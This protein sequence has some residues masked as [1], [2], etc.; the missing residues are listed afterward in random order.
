MFDEVFAPGGVLETR[1]SGYE[2]RAG[3]RQMA[4]AVKNAIGRRSILLAEAGTGT[5]KTFAYC[6]PAILSGKR[7]VIS[8]ATKN[9][10][11]QIAQ[12]DLPRLCEALSVKARI[13]VLKGR[14][15]YLCLH[16]LRKVG[17]QP[18]VRFRGRNETLAEIMEW[19]A[20]TDT[21]DRAELRTLPDDYLPWREL[22]ARSDICLGPRCSEYEQCFVTRA[23]QAAAAADIVVVNHALF[24]ADLALRQQ[25]NVDSTVLPAYDVVIFDEAH[26]L[27]DA[28]T[29][30]FGVTFSE[31]RV[32]ELQKDVLQ[33]LDDEPIPGAP[34][35]K[36][37]LAELPMAMGALFHALGDTRDS[38]A[39][40][41]TRGPLLQLASEVARAC[42][43]LGDELQEASDH[44]SA[45]RAAWATLSQR[46]KKLSYEVAFVF[47]PEQ[48]EAAPQFARMIE[49]RARSRSIKALPL[50]VGGVLGNTIFDDGSTIILTSATLSVGGDF[51]VLRQRL[52]IQAAEEIVVDSPFDYPHRALVYVPAQFPEPNAPAYNDTLGQR[53]LELCDASKGGAFFL[54]T[55]LAQL[56]RQAQAIGP[57]LRAR[58]HLVFKQGDAPKHV[59]IEDFARDGSAVL[60]ASASFWEGVD[61]PGDALRLVCIDK[62]PFASPTDPLLAARIAEAERR[63]E[64]AFASHQLAPAV[65]ALRQG[66]GR[67]IRTAQD[68]GVVAILDVRLRS[69]SYGKKFLAALPPAP[70]TASLDDV[71]A[72]FSRV[73]SVHDR[74]PAN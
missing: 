51:S 15:N 74:S 50:D 7:V 17:K 14:Q 8:T 64:S 45:A 34:E 55:S 29:D 69:R 4:E 46:A 36:A 47:A 70:K 32:A 21:G 43:R 71:R 23:R 44:A 66:F 38:K 5:G 19:A 30:H 67:L 22:D 18:S 1:L 54:F 52:G 16:R 31:N 26:A 63:G 42:D 2:V 72:F 61:V 35:V 28:V 3:Q 12:R 57:L 25:P 56:E 40:P 37:A 33:A 24:F 62:L 48:D 60:F 41:D 13:S 49:Q 39:L 9:L 27:E 6:V 68:R 10:Q 59:L 53:L 11:D 73:G 58:G 65:L 20:A